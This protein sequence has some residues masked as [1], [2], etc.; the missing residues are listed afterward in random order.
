MAPALV[1]LHLTTCRA[2][3]SVGRA[4]K[5]QKSGEHVIYFEHSFSLC[6]RVESSMET[7]PPWPPGIPWKSHLVYHGRTTLATW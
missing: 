5:E 7:W 3:F 6:I 2:E 1:F 4:L